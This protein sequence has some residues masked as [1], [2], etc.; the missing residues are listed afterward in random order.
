MTRNEAKAIIRKEYL[1]V[2]RDCDIERNCGKCDLMM[3]SKEPILEAYKLAIKALEYDDA[4]YHEE[5]G[6]VIVAKGLWEDA[7]K[8]LEQEP[9]CC[10]RNICLKNE[11]N[12]IGCD[13]CEVTKSQE[14]CE[15][16]AAKLQ[17]A[18]NK[19]FENCRQALLDT[20]GLSEKT[21]K[22]GGDHSG[23]NTMML[24]EIQDVIES[25]P[26]VNPQPTGHWKRIS[27][28]KYFEHA[29]YWY[30]CD[31]CGKDNL[32]NTDWCPNCGC[33]MVEPKER[34]E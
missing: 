16:E 2:D 31:R 20:F 28:D 22:W 8:A 32:G 24:Y 26:S 14:P 5:H 21:R 23:Y 13:E 17:Q 18:Y 11:Y 15:V 30:R 4:K 6:E 34:S 25:Q 10:D 1:C 9:A 29:K 12:G 3:P 27:M 7:K 19:G 33:R